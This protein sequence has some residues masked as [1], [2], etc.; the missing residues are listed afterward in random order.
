MLQKK[1]EPL[2]MDR[3]RRQRK[4]KADPDNTVRPSAPFAPESR[5]PATHRPGS[6][7][8]APDTAP[9]II[10]AHDSESVCEFVDERQ[11]AR[12][13]Q[14]RVTPGSIHVTSGNSHVTPGNSHVTLGISQSVDSCAVSDSGS[15]LVNAVVTTS[16]ENQGTFQDEKRLP[17][18]AGSTS[19]IHTAVRDKVRPPL[20]PPPLPPKPQII[21]DPHGPTRIASDRKFAPKRQMTTNAVRGLRVLP[22][23]ASLNTA[24]EKLSLKTYAGGSPLVCKLTV[25][26]VVE[27]GRP[28]PVFVDQPDADCSAVFVLEPGASCGPQWLQQRASAPGPQGHPRGERVEEARY[29]RGHEPKHGRL[30]PQPAHQRDALPHKKTV[31]PLYPQPGHAGRSVTHSGRRLSLQSHQADFPRNLFRRFSE[32]Q[33]MLLGKPDM[34]SLPSLPLTQERLSP[35]H[36]VEYARSL[37]SPQPSDKE[38]SS[39]WADRR[40]DAKSLRVRIQQE[41]QALFLDKDS[42]LP[43]AKTETKQPGFPFTPP[44]REDACCVGRPSDACSVGRPSQ[45]EYFILEPQSDVSDDD[46]MSDCGQGC[47]PAT[48]T[49]RLAVRPTPAPRTVPRQAETDTGG[50]IRYQQKPAPPGIPPRPP[51]V[52]RAAGHTRSRSESPVC[53][54]MTKVIRGGEG[55]GEQG[56]VVVSLKKVRSVEIE[57]KQMGPPAGP[58]DSPRRP[59]VRPRIRSEPGCSQTS[60]L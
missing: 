55:E 8:E 42:S 39:P 32:D 20:P 5:P 44:A 10:T 12:D 4:R 1:N 14:N 23:D 40:L 24:L 25:V 60:D 11:P 28:R 38:P 35:A 19:N 37:S 18:Q 46:M 31:A 13:K 54:V 59:S 51:H 48:P 3:F 26:G 34:K 58:P 17:K 22:S 50:R 47:A 30:I 57:G 2:E 45:N 7:N 43:H 52:T 53:Q 36:K 33:C 56:P 9:D 21:P 16:W 27:E 29:D 41:M 15:V 6:T 49:R